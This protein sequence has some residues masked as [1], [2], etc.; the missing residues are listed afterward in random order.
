MPE[1]ESSQF[2]QPSNNFPPIGLSTKFTDHADHA[3]PQEVHLLIVEDDKGRREITLGADVYSIGRDPHCNIRLYSMFVSRRHATLVRQER[4]EGSYS[5]QIV[6]GNLQG[7]LSA[8]GIL[9]NGRKLPTKD[10]HDLEHEDYVVFGPGVS[11][12]YQLLKR[13]IDP[14]DITLIDP[15]MVD[16]S[17][18]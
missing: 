11:A 9:I 12:R 7:Q 1:A 16:P 6:D 13:N 2:N 17:E 10:T 18:T 15:G 14:F 4:E 5:Y 3:D 8:N